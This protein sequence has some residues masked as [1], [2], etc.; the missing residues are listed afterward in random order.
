M[1]SEHEFRPSSWNLSQTE[2]DNWSLKGDR[3]MTIITHPVHGWPGLK[4]S[5]DKRPVYFVEDEKRQ[6]YLLVE[7]TKPV[8]EKEDS[9]LVFSRRPMGDPKQK[10]ESKTK[11]HQDFGE[12]GIITFQ[13]SDNLLNI[14]AIILV[15]NTRIAE[16]RRLEEGKLASSFA[17][18]KRSSNAREIFPR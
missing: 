13:L 11:Y 17:E 9:N 15:A 8:Q 7:L 12:Y 10:R 5:A 4:L 6:K 1:T 14:S 3:E 16:A 18:F 2:I